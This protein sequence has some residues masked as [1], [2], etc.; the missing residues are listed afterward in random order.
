[1]TSAKACVDQLVKTRR[2]KETEGDVAEPKSWMQRFVFP[3]LR[4]PRTRL[5]DC[6]SSELAH[7]MAQM[8]TDAHVWQDP[9]VLSG[10]TELLAERKSTD[11]L[12]RQ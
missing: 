3:P 6:K 2:N 4:N 10:L 8:E 9:S 7:A 12:P 1:L 11:A 5:T